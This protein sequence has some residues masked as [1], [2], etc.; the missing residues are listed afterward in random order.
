[1]IAIPF[2]ELENS[3]ADWRL[4]DNVWASEQERQEAKR[5]SIGAE[6]PVAFLRDGHLLCA[7][8]CHGG[9]GRFPLVCYCGKTAYW[10]SELRRTDGKIIVPKI[11]TEFSVRPFAAQ[12]PGSSA[13]IDMGQSIYGPYA[14]TAW[15]ITEFR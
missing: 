12:A 3:S 11:R 2:E 4:L 8:N 9:A 7:A 10:D 14:V 5:L 13:L 6:T 15:H 1:M